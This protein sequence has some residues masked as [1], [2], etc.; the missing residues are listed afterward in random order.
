MAISSIGL[1]SYT[2]SDLF[3]GL[4]PSNGA[5]RL[6]QISNTKYITLSTNKII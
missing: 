1:T 6:A 2:I 3:L 5:F 4:N